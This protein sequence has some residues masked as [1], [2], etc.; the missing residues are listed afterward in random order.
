MYAPRSIR[1]RKAQRS[2]QAE[3]VEDHECQATRLDANNS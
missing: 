2:Y 1:A 3:I